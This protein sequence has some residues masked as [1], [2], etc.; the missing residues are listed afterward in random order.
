MGQI[1]NIKLHIVTDIK[2]DKHSGLG[3]KQSIMIIENI[4]VFK[5][6]LVKT[7]EPICDAD[8]AA[9]AKYVIALA[10]KD[11]PQPELQAL[12]ED[13]LD[14]FL[15]DDTKGFV[16]ELFETLSS[17]SYLQMIK[18]EGPLLV[19]KEEPREEAN[20]EPGKTDSEKIQRTDDR[21]DVGNKPPQPQQQHTP[22]SENDKENVNNQKQIK[23]EIDEYEAK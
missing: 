10:K 21:A 23:K 16:K 9:L 20:E 12:C 15:G 1:K 14:V 8:P 4:D 13:Q 5:T 7:L 3:D 17:K 19:K 18:P 2:I 11:K 22:A 6:W